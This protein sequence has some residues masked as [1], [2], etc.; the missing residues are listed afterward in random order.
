[1]NTASHISQEDLA[2]IALQLLPEDE[3]TEAL[4]H[5]EHCEACRSELAA[6]QGDL[7]IFAMTSEMHSPPALARDRLMKRVAKE[8]KIVPFERMSERMTDRSS[9]RVLPLDPILPPAAPIAIDEPLL[10]SRSHSMFAG[11]DAPE[12]PVRKSRVTAIAA[13]TGWAIAAGIAVVAGMQFH[14]RQSL[15]DA[16]NN[17]T[18][19]LAATTSA[20]TAAAQA[21]RTLTSQ[22]AMQVA[23]HIQPPEGVPVVHLPEGHAAYDKATG[24]LIFVATNMLPLQQGKTYELWVLPADSKAAPVAAGTFRPDERGFA[25]VVMPD[26]PKGVAAQGFGVTLENAGGA[27]SPT[28]PPVLMGTSQEVGM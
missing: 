11:Y 8:K 21:L 1:M 28:M 26:I 27:K 7:A 6:L 9:E 17:T 19:K 12:E 2:L 15:Q 4:T 14:Q 16:L 20:E 13:W 10:N 23:M 24:S 25:T 22:G 3:T 5:L 18:A